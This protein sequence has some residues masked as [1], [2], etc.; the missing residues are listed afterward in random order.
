MK[1]KKRIE[2]WLNIRKKKLYFSV[3]KKNISKLKKWILNSKKIHHVSGKFFQILGIRINSNFFIKNTWDQPIIFQNEKGI[4]GIIRYYNRGKSEYLLQ[5]KAEP[6]NINKLQLSPTVQ[7]TRSNYNR[8]HS[9]KEVKYLNFF[10]NLNRRK[11]LINSPQT[12]QGGRYLYKQ[13]RN[14]MINIASKI[15]PNPNYIWITKQEIGECINKNNFLNMDSISVF[16]CAIKKNFYDFPENSI[17]NIN[18]WFKKLKKKYFIKRKIIPLSSMKNWNYDQ[19]NIIHKS[20]KYFSVIGVKIQSNSREISEWEQPIIKEINMGLSGF[21]VKK[22]NST[23]H[24]LVRFSLKP[25]LK[26]PR[27]TCTVRTSDAKSCLIN[28]NYSSLRDNDLM[29]YYIKKYFTKN[30][31]GKIIYNKIH[32]DEGGR[33]FHSQSKNIIVQIANDDNVKINSNYT[34]MSYNQVLHFIKKGIFNIEA[35]ILF[36]CFNIKNIL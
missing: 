15:K 29:K 35:R 31:K 34:W 22:I 1:N 17:K 25:G 20:K 21:I 7:A 18:V 4:L 16:S 23:Y 36:T 30:N 12:E 8:V 6:G 9:G 13:N 33:F 26:D 14:I 11:V 5:A 27:L 2:R 24:Y 19:K 28:K 10:K 32:S 3:K